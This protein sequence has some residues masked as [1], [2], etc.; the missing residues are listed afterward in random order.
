MFLPEMINDE[1][2]DTMWLA[3]PGTEMVTI[4][5]QLERPAQVGTNQ[6]INDQSPHNVCV[7]VH[8]GFV[9]FSQVTSMNINMIH[10]VP[11]QYLKLSQ[12]MRDGSM[13][14]IWKF[15]NCGPT[16]EDSIDVRCL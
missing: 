8:L 1:S 3:Q 4:G 15:R 12:R 11:S 9:L 16:D 13:E 10:A 5:F 2:Y 14:V 7:Q 6:N